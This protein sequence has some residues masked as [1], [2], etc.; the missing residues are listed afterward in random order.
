MICRKKKKKK[1]K[2]KDSVLT[3]ALHQHCTILSSR[4][5]VNQ[6]CFIGNR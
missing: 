4:P 2:E 5:R 1:L 6:I 3:A